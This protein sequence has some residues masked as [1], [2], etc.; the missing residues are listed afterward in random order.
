MYPQ[1]SVVKLLIMMKNA[2][3]RIERLLMFFYNKT[4][5]G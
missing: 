3:G 1:I 2:G 4:I 5:P